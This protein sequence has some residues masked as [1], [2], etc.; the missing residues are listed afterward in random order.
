MKKV[1]TIW[2][3]GIATVNL[4]DIWIHRRIE[5]ELNLIFPQSFFYS[6][7]SN[8]YLKRY[9]RY[10]R[11]SSFVF[12]AGT[13]LISSR[14][15]FPYTKQWKLKL[16]DTLFIAELV[17]MGVGW[18]SYDKILSIYHIKISIIPIL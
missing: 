1:N 18:R 2:S 8:D 13:N 4:S 15:H 17:L 3:P 11:K 12:A 6:I 14:M 5:H 16:R 9:R 7:P 10:T